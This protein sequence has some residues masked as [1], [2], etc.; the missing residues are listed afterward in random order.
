MSLRAEIRAAI[1][2]VT[3]PAPTLQHKVEAFV[4]ANGRD[5]VVPMHR[6]RTQWSRPFRGP[7]SLVA[8]VLLVVLI[9][10]LV[11][12]GR[13]LRD[14]NAPPQTINQAEL[15]RLESRPLRAMPSVR[16]DDPCP[17][18]PL[19]DVSAHGPEAVLL[20]DGPV[21]STR[22]GAQSVTS[23]NWGTWSVWSVLVDKTKASG[24]ILIRARDLQT[25]AEV[26]FGW[27]PLTANGQAGDGI[28]T[29]RAT[30][31]DVVL[32]QTEHLYPEVVLDLSR[33]F[34]LTKAG[35]WPIFKSFIGY[36]KAAAG[37]IGFQIDGTNFTGT[38]F[39]ELIVVS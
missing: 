5:R 26:V 32:G 3:P 4:V 37:C 21:Y 1:D 36:P 25:H 8:A 31:T 27:N 18:S 17:T 7:M 6:P 9:G 11:L 28:P 30:G 23:T 10:G 33:P 19:T 15:K 35:D 38:N 24:P 14:L 34:A 2:D 16:P 13:L 12:G 39:T 29:G 22:L 20:G